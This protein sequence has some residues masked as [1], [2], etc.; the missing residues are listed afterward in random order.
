[1]IEINLEQVLYP[2]YPEFQPT[3]NH[4]ELMI[5]IPLENHDYGLKILNEPGKQSIV[6]QR[7]Q[8]QSVQE[9][10]KIK[11]WVNQV[12][13]P[14]WKQER[15]AKFVVGNSYPSTDYLMEKWEMPPMEISSLDLNTREMAKLVCAI[16]QVP[17]Y[18]TI[19]ESLHKVFDVYF[20][21][22]QNQM[23]E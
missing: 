3:L 4:P 2:F 1:M 13:S 9:Q 12:A 16:L 21:F 6:M 23:F 20:G 11:E 8:V 22:E 18:Q 17:V 14:Q 19:V 15:Q 7:N 10:W 5:G